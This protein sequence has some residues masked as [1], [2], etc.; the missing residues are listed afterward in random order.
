[1]Q[2]NAI[3][4]KDSEFYKTSVRAANTQDMVDN[5]FVHWDKLR[6]ITNA[7][8]G[9]L[10]KRW[11]KRNVLNRKKVL[12]DAW[13]GMNPM[14][15]PDFDVI[16]RQLKGPAY[17]DALMMPYINLEDLSSEK[18]LL[19]FMKSRAKVYPEHFAWSDSQPFKIAATMH[20]VKPAAQYPKVML[21]T[22]QKS[23]DTYGKL[24]TVDMVDVD[25]TVW[26]RFAFQLSPELI[27]LETQQRLYRFLCR[28][29]ELLL[30]D[31]HLSG[32][33]FERYRVDL[34]ETPRLVDTTILSES[35]E[36][37]SVSK[38]NALASY[39]LPRPFSLGSLRRLANAQRDAAK[40]AFWALHE[41]PVYFQEQLHLETQQF[42]EPCRKAFGAHT[43]K[44]NALM[45]AC[46]QVV[47][48]AC[49]DIILW[50]AIEVDLMKISA[51][52]IEHDA[53]IHLSK[54]LPPRYE[55]ALYDFIGLVFTAW[56]YAM[57]GLR[58]ILT[59]SP[60]FIDYFE[61]AVTNDG[62]CVDFKTP[63]AS[64]RSRW[65]PILTLLDDLNFKGFK[66]MGALNILD[67]MERIMIS[68]TVQRNMV[69]TELA[70]EISK[71]A[72]LAQIIDALY[73]RQ[74]TIQPRQD[75][76]QILRHHVAR[77]K[78]I[79]D[80]EDYLTGTSLGPFTKPTSAFI[81][82]VE[83]KRTLQQVER[84]RQAETKLDISWRQVDT[85]IMRHTGR[86][87]LDWMGNRITSRDLHRTRPW[88]PELPKPVELSPPETPFQPFPDSAPDTT[89]RF[90]TEL[91]KKPKTRGE[92]SFAIES[93][94]PAPAP[95]APKL[96]TPKFA[97][98]SK[99]HKTMRALFPPSTQDRTS[100][101][102][103]WKDFLHAMYSLG[104]QI[105]K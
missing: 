3:S 101:K 56:R 64:A 14:H 2:F 73:Q 23:R 27:V 59:T 55:E 1:M 102:V 82:P 88:Q 76:D 83:K 93:T 32:A 10:E 42:I 104:F 90:P 57:N 49:R 69:N 103:A 40:D 15:R 67:E 38:M 37:Q 86:T 11:A 105:Q 29:A 30:H 79:D 84:M 44:E 99:V 17:R 65:P 8:T 33:A 13:P 75:S 9:A 89:E 74:P 60:T 36:W 19:C 43:V 46:I 31:L 47:R 77:L 66:T 87:L 62:R 97:L 54:R 6:M 5:I 50:E 96:S 91:R 98:S 61:M 7:H 24:Q 41:E 28:C 34:K 16:R 58:N 51:L 53:E 39:H 25:N 12:L 52:K 78:A 100:R 85:K 70:K 26:T 68:D 22:G 94:Q 35:V 72:A 95:S 63:K 45:S 80:L 92:A 20:A 71:V 4:S 81:Y 48:G 21:L 18:N